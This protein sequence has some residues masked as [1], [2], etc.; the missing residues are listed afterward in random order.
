[1]NSNDI[2]LRANE[3]VLWKGNKSKDYIKARYDFYYTIAWILVI[4]V[5]LAGIFFVFLIFYLLIS[6]SYNIF[7]LIIIILA[8]CII[9]FL[10]LMLKK[11]KIEI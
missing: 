3:R 5:I 10:P 2:D 9:W 7:I 6:E 1:M 4:P 11:E 8:E